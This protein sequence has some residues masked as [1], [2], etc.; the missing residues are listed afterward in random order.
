MTALT[1]VDAERILYSEARLLDAR[2][3]QAWLEML[4][5]GILY[6]MPAWRDDGT[7]TADPER[8]LS[9]IYYS[10][11]HNLEDRVRRLLAG[12]S[13]ASRM[14]QR[15]VHAITNVELELRGPGEATVL[16]CFISSVFDPRADRIA[17]FFGRNEHGLRCEGGRWLIT[18]KIIRLANDI[19]PSVLDVNMV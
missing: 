12:Q 8:E 1:L 7:Q 2:D 16:S 10:G 15:V 18:R 14:P 4:D 9:L 11:K 6:W 5:P 13:A 3:F 17:Q 19:V